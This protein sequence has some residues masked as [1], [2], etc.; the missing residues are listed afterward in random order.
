MAKPL[1]NVSYDLTLEVAPD[2]LVYPGDPPPELRRLSSL[3]AGDELTSSSLSLSCHAG[4][5]VDAPAHFLKGGRWLSDFPL[6]AFFGPAQVLEITGVRR[7]TAAHLRH[8]QLAS[9]HH[10][11][12][13]TDNSAALR[14]ARF[15]PEHAYL[16]EDAAEYL[17]R[18]NPRSIGFDYYSV[19][20]SAPGAGLPVHR[21]FAQRDLLVYACLDLAL[22]AAGV[23][24][25][26]GLPLRLRSVEAAPVRAMLSALES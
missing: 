1:Q 18:A 12:L 3:E 23:Y 4:T 6:E 8:A 2:M 20:R 15:D 19:D 25:F 26:H 13:R 16:T 9:E 21:R 22:V 14:S 17:L 10:L 24:A 7:I 5:H 11:L